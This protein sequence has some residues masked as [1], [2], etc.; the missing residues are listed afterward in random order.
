M[1][2]LAVGQG[3][4]EAIDYPNVYTAPVNSGGMVVL[5]RYPILADEVRTFRNL[6]WEAMPDNRR[7]DDSTTGTADEFVVPLSSKSH[8]DV[9]I[10]IDGIALHV[11]A[12]QPAAPAD[13]ALR[14][15]DEIR[16]WADYIAADDMSW[17]VDDAGLTGGLDATSEFV[18]VGD[19]NADPV[20]GGSVEGAIQ[21][22]LDLDRIQDP[23]PTS[24][25][26]VE[27]AEQQG[28]ANATQRGDPALDTADFADDPSPGNLRTDYVLPSDGLDIVDTGVFW[29][30]S[31]DPL[32]TLV[33]G[34]PIASS[35]HH[36]VW[37]DV[38]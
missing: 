1:N 30:P 8:W 12:S 4:A 34:E 5:S 20:D 25:G 18:I 29:P 2:Y 23:Q 24:E 36:L 38:H 9:P 37:A 10:D 16:F 7:V 6:P 31:D 32:S 11:L 15:A 35:D 19:L 21:Q 3:G 17:I 13:D 27:A 28:A 26:A 33:G 22:L 14:N